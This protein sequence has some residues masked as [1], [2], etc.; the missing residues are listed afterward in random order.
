MFGYGILGKTQW[1]PTLILCL[2]GGRWGERR[3]EWKMT[4]MYYHLPLYSTLLLSPLFQ[5]YPKVKIVVWHGKCTI[6]S[7]LTKQGIRLTKSLCCRVS[8][9]C[10]ASFSSLVIS[11]IQEVSCRL[12]ATTSYLVGFA[13]NNLILGLS[14]VNQL[15][16][17]HVLPARD[18]DPI[19]W[20]YRIRL[21]NGLYKSSSQ[22]QGCMLSQSF[23]NRS[24]YI[25]HDLVM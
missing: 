17:S 3:G 15:D 13:C 22:S 23:V 25:K 4:R 1:H 11:V 19:G 2:D 5:T 18:W 7:Q 24:C 8:Y 9:W 6:F 21:T 14:L 16:L 20:F 10:R 12:V